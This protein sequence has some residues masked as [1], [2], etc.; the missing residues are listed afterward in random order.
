MKHYEVVAAVIEYDGKILCM[1]RNEGKF[2][3]VSYKFEFPGGKV[4]AGEEN[5]T[6]L[7]REL[8]EEMDMNVSISEDDYLMTVNH[9]YPDFA[10]T[11][12]AY[13]CKVDKPDFVRKEHCFVKNE[14][15]FERKTE[16]VRTWDYLMFAVADQPNLSEQSIEA[17]IGAAGQRFRQGY[18]SQTPTFSLCCGER[19]GNPCMF[20]A[21]LIPELMQLEGDKGGRSVLKKHECCYVEIENEEEFS[22]IDTEEQMK[23][24]SGREKTSAKGKKGENA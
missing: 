19:V 13:L 9:T 3:Y 16:H 10:I 24:M 23:K 12:H 22:D 20:R 7:E 11:M 14:R 4:E 8:R 18:T 1:Q 6:A 21:D 5:H 2:D 17:L 15:S